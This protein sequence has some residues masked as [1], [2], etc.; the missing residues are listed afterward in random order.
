MQTGF[1]VCIGEFFR[2]PDGNSGNSHTWDMWNQASVERKNRTKTLI[3]NQLPFVKCRNQLQ[4]WRRHGRTSIFN[5]CTIEMWYGYFFNCLNAQITVICNTRSAGPFYMLMCGWFGLIFVVVLG[6]FSR[7][8]T[9]RVQHFSLS[10]T[11]NVLQ[12]FC[13]KCVIVLLDGTGT[14]GY[15]FWKVTSA[16]S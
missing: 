15:I 4:N 1:T 2:T 3:I 14:P 8:D 12:N 11:L 5:F 16:S 7:S 6:Y 13:T 9:V 10:A